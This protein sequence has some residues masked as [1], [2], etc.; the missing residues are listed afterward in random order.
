MIHFVL[1]SVLKPEFI[2]QSENWFELLDD[3]HAD[4]PFQWK[5]GLDRC[6]AGIWILDKPIPI[7][8]DK[9]GEVSVLTNRNVVEV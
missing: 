9:H 5:G 7:R 4:G 8:T 3:L 6:T 1:S 2:L